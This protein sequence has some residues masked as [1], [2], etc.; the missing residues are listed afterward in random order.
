MKH[1]ENSSNE[2]MSSE[3][4]DVVDE[5]VVESKSYIW[6]QLT[7]QLSYDKMYQ[8]S[9]SHIQSSSNGVHCLVFPT[10]SKCDHL[11]PHQKSNTRRAELTFLALVCSFVH[12]PTLGIEY[13]SMPIAVFQGPA[14][15]A[16][17]TSSSLMSLQGLHTPLRSCVHRDRMG[18]GPRSIT[19]TNPQLCLQPKSLH[20]QRTPAQPTFTS[21]LLSQPL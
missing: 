4:G 17:I 21:L 7:S 1:R 2:C 10:Q 16:T 6:R 9:R 12:P 5:L 11:S 15:N 13:S 14:S 19:S 3:D 8:V 20:P 18:E